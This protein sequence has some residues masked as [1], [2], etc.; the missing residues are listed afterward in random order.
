MMCRRGSA[1]PGG[2][3]VRGNKVAKPPI[4]FICHLPVVDTASVCSVLFLCCRLGRRAS[5]LMWWHRK[6]MQA[7]PR[8]HNPR[9]RR[10][11]ICSASDLSHW[12]TVNSTR[13]LYEDPWGR[14]DRRFRPQSPHPRRKPTFSY[15]MKGLVSIQEQG[16][17]TPVQHV[18]CG[19]EREYEPNTLGCRLETAGSSMFEG[20]P[21]TH[22][23][24]SRCLRC[25]RCADCQWGR[26]IASLADS[27]RRFNSLTAHRLPI[28]ATTVQRGAS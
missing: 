7:Q 5:P 24:T 8:G 23:Y 15:L 26:R 4:I 20:L 12:S 27:L 6:T 3:K 16:E 11:S 19:P 10:E 2:V 28:A 22:S 17:Q 13:A 18:G 1:T 9:K 21:R 14:S 25:R